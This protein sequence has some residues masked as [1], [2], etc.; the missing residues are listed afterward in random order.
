MKK[1][2]FIFIIIII[3]FIL[4]LRLGVRFIYR[5]RM[6]GGQTDLLPVDPEQ[7]RMIDYSVYDG[8]LRKYVRDGAVDYIRWKNNDFAIFDK[9]IRTCASKLK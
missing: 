6:P 3:S 9:Y 1:K 8:L 2:I 4:F 5:E 7:S